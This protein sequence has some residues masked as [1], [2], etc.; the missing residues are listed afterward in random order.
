MEEKKSLELRG[1]KVRSIVG[2]IPSSLIRYGIMSIGVVL[3]ALLGVAYFMPYK[4]VYSGS[5][6]IYKVDVV[7]TDSTETSLWLK[8][9]QNRMSDAEGETITLISPDS[10]FTGRLLQLSDIRD[11]EERQEALCRFATDE[12]VLVQGQTVDFRIDRTSGNLLHKLL[13]GS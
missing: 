12:I 8:F 10:T 3:V 7:A 9:E 2:R 13:G 1:E 5:A 4:Q 6:T 11:T